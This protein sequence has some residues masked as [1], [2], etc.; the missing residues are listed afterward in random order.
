M[1]SLALALSP[2]IGEFYEYSN[3]S[4]GIG[5]CVFALAASVHDSMKRKNIHKF[6]NQFF[7]VFAF[8]LLDIR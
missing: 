3:F 1:N 7:I 5:V 2:S 6:T 8:I 4:A